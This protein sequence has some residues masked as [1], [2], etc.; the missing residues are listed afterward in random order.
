MKP[1]A[2][3]IVGCGYMGSLHARKPARLSGSG[4]AR[5]VGVYD[6]DPKESSKARRY[7][8]VSFDEAISKN[9]RVMDQT[10]LALCRENDVPIVVFDMFIDGN[11]SRLMRGERLGS[12][13]AASMPA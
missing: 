2:V 8:T 10:A 6:A 1:P 7:D 9:L 11:L 3:A 12:I 13:V 4:E 5:L